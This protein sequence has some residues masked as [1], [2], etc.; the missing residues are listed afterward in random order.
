MPPTF[1]DAVLDVGNVAEAS[2]SRGRSARQFFQE[3]FEVAKNFFR[4]RGFL[5]KLQR[6]IWGELCAAL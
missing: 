1:D 6:A 5:H 2:G 3:G 4:S